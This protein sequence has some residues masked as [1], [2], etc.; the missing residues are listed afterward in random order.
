MASDFCSGVVKV[1]G[2]PLVYHVYGQG[3]VCVAH[4]GG[5]GGEWAIC[6]YRSSSRQ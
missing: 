3:P 6:G 1:D 2:V 5:P 4:P